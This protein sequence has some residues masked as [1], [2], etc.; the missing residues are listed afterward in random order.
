LNRRWIWLPAALLLA[1]GMAFAL[2]E[3]MGW[4]F[5][6][7]PLQNQLQQKLGRSLNLR[8]Q[9]DSGEA[10]A[11]L[12]FWGGIRLQSPVLEIGAPA[13][14]KTPY[15]LSA[16]AIDVRLR[17]GDIWRAWRGQQLV[18]QSLAAQQLTVYVER[19]ADGRASWQLAA[20][21]G[22]TKPPR[23]ENMEVLAG[24]LHVADAPLA[25]TL[26]ADL[27]LSSATTAPS[28]LS[29]QQ[30]PQSRVLHVSARGQYRKDAFQVS[31]QST[32]ALPWEVEAAQ[33]TPVAVKLKASVGPASLEFD[34]MARDFLHL[35]GLDGTFRV[36]GSSLAAIGAPLG[37]TLPT[38]PAFNASGRVQR[39][40]ALWTLGLR[41]ARVGASQL[42]GDFVF[43]TAAKPPRLTG[44]LK[45]TLLKLVDLGPAVGAAAGAPKAK[46]L[47]TRP[48][49]LAALRAMDADVHIA[50]DQVDANTSLLEPL[51]PLAAH[52]QLT[53]GL[54]TLTDI[55]ARTAQGH[56]GGTLALDGQQDRAH[57]V[58]ALN[59]DGVQLQRWI[60]QQRAAPQPPY[61]TGQMQ[62]HAT[63]QGSGRSTAEILATLQGDISATVENGTLSHL[64]MEMGGLDLAQ[65]LGVLVKGDNALVLDCALAD[66]SV[67][68]G[69]LRPRLLV[70]DTSDSTVWVDGSVSLATEQLD[71]RAVV[72]PKDFSL[73]TLRSPLHIRGSFAAPAVTVEKG[74][75]GLKLG[76]A[77]LLGL[78]NPL[79]A[80][81]P[82]VDAGSRTQAQNNAASC[83]ARMH[84]KLQ[85]GLPAL[86]R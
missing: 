40:G 31:L 22:A 29:T 30:T 12:H 11:T 57:W 77:L 61:V 19:L 53:S 42:R 67:A 45:G 28:T 39:S 13:W 43:D 70:L 82:L 60:H 62:G 10:Q 5:L 41:T 56:L 35:N 49:D 36:Q 69:T 7:A 83:Q 59:W 66:L 2:A 74:P 63:L 16:K 52:L 79:A 85:G 9:T 68:A 23:V 51:R 26:D 64:L 33:G 55:E 75:L 8:A 65:S 6:V 38:T 14:S 32:G 76:A 27:T 24:T 15:L 84:R 78:V 73:L 54:L 4:P 48:F 34:G 21:G 44:D 37:I 47:P 80:I 1:M 72:A 71:L 17:Y 50:I 25:F 58:A 18:V 86:Q 81:L 46:V 3:S 20:G